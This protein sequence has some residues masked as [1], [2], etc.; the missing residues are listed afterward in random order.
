MTE[1][2]QNKDK[3]KIKL[4]KVKEFISNRPALSNTLKEF[5][6]IEETDSRENMDLL[7]TVVNNEKL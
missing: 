6:Q 1:Y 5:I 4:L 7:N 2:F 3:I